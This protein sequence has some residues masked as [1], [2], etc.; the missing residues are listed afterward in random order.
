MATENTTTAPATPA[1]AA[2]TSGAK[3]IMTMGGLGLVCGVLIVAAFQLTLPRIEKNKAAALEKAIFEVIPGATTKTVLSE[4]D[5]RLVPA[6]DVPGGMHYYAGYDDQHH[7]VGVAVEASGQG[8]ADLLKVLYGYSPDDGA[9]V[10][11]KV[12]ESHET[13]GLGSKIESDPSF[14]ANFEA[15]AVRVDDAGTGIRNPVTLAKHGE[16]TQAW[17]IEAI[18]GATISSR[19]VTDILHSSTAHTVPVIM[20][21]LQTLQSSQPEGG[22]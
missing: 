6:S 14:R 8:F 7:L 9:V 10:G 11:M 12:L 16:K 19:A 1:P 15:L 3:M 2:G 21:N 18:T 20:S 5:G 17:E 4:K 22:Q 13:P